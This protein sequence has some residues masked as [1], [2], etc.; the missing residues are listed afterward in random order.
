MHWSRVIRLHVFFWTLRGL[1]KSMRGKTRAFL[2]LSAFGGSPNLMDLAPRSLHSAWLM[3][4]HPPQWMHLHHRLPM[5]CWTVRGW[6]KA[7]TARLLLVAEMYPGITPTT[8]QKNQVEVV[9]WGAFAVAIAFSSSWSSS[10]PSW[11]SIS[12]LFTNLRCLPTKFKAW[13]SNPLISCLI[14]A[15]TLCFW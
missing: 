9:A 12:T 14:S 4:Y 11:L 8:T 3:P 10:S 1:D 7:T 15:S 13:M 5:S 6:K 2:S